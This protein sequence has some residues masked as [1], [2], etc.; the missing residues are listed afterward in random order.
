MA[1]IA[2]LSKE[3][4]ARLAGRGKARASIAVAVEPGK[5]PELVIRLAV[6]SRPTSVTVAYP[7]GRSETFDVPEV[8]SAEVIDLMEAL[9]AAVTKS[10][11]EVRTEA[12]RKASK[13]DR[14][15]TDTYEPPPK[16]K[17]K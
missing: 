8:S 3:T 2:T 14:S 5:V 15:V 17:R 12:R 1:I 4:I 10:F 16:R 13:R 6:A 9:R 7:D 11:S